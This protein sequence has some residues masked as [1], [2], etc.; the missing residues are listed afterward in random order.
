[1]ED[2]DNYIYSISENIPTY[3]GKAGN[4]YNAP[5]ALTYKS[6]ISIASDAIRTYFENHYSQSVNEH[7][8]DLMVGLTIITLIISTSTTAWFKII[9][10]IDEGIGIQS[11]L[12]D[13]HTTLNNN[14]SNKGIP[15]KPFFS[16]L[17]QTSLKD[18]KCVLCSPSA[19]KNFSLNHLLMPFYDLN[20]TLM[21][22]TVL[23]EDIQAEIPSNSNTKIFVVNSYGLWRWCIYKFKMDLD[24]G[25][26]HSNSKVCYFIHN[27][28]EDTVSSTPLSSLILFVGIII[29]L[30]KLENDMH[31][32]RGPVTPSAKSD[33]ENEDEPPENGKNDIKMI[34]KLKNL[35]RFY[36]L[37]GGRAYNIG[38][39]F[40]LSCLAFILLNTCCVLSSK[41][42]F[43]HIK[44][45][46]ISIRSIE[47]LRSFKC[48]NIKIKSRIEKNLLDISVEK[49]LSDKLF[50]KFVQHLNNLDS[51][52]YDA[53]N[54]T[55]PKSKKTSQKIIRKG[56]L[57][58]LHKTASPSNLT[59]GIIPNTGYNETSD[60]EILLL[61]ILLNALCQTLK[62]DDNNNEDL[63]SL[64]R[65][66]SKI[67]NDW[68][69]QMIDDEQL[70]LDSCDFAIYF[71]I[72]NLIKKFKTKKYLTLNRKFVPTLKNFFKNEIPMAEIYGDL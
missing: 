17:N 12:E 14:S 72:M 19:L 55:I 2:F 4:D 65:K 36:I 22:N 6:K 1:M 20:I 46:I 58:C 3:E 11:G 5:N 24:K 30:S 34:I 59:L 7:F 70:C 13:Y 9:E 25:N 48:A 62:V 26:E 47:R 53:A 40:K 32:K 35:A 29:M 33:T 52:N 69:S 63:Q 45:N 60:F 50:Q 27:L 67:P 23:K 28:Q 21:D 41:P 61:K 49:S 15:L 54:T 43:K 8:V 68:L 31:L 37:S 10:S 39:S 16:F 51:E 44:A 42:I 71:E 38:P 56:I 57:D 64:Q 18:Y 66:L